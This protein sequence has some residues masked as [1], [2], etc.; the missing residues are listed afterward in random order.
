MYN[1]SNGNQSCNAQIKS[2]SNNFKNGQ[3]QNAKVGLTK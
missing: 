3:N 2:T 1:C